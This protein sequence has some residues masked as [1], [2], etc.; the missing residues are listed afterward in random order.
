[1]EG[2]AEFYRNYYRPLVSRFFGRSI[3]AESIHHEQSGYASQL[4]Q[5]LGPWLHDVVPGAELLDIGGSTGVVAS[6]FV[7]TFGYQSTVLDPAPDELQIARARGLEVVD[8]FLEYYDPGTRRFDLVLMCQTIDHLLKLNV[9]LDRIRELV[10]PDGYFFCDIVDFEETCYV[11]GCIEGA[12]HVDHCYYVSQETASWM[13]SSFGWAVIYVDIAMRPG[14]V[15][16][17][18]K[19]GNIDRTT[20]PLDTSARLRGLQRLQTQWHLASQHTYGVARWLR[21]RAYRAKQYLRRLHNYEEKKTCSNAA[22]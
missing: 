3:T 6:E 11:T 2:Y 17:L 20:E 12:L 21:K 10:K 1:M 9:S 7:Q 22:S 5:S 4:A 14:H 15:G 19:P 8:G 13:F 18:L 16:Y